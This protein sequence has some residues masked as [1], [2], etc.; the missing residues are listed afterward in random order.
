MLSRLEQDPDYV[1]HPDYAARLRE[2][3]GLS[4]ADTLAISDDP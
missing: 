1:V 3:L 2:A 4:E